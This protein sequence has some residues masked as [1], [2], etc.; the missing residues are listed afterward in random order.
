MTSDHSRGRSSAYDEY[1]SMEASAQELAGILP[2]LH[3]SKKN[4]CAG[5]TLQ[6]I[7]ATHMLRNFT[8]ALVKGFTSRPLQK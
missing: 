8:V 6:N 5:T 2:V 3:V 7:R 4:G 1:G